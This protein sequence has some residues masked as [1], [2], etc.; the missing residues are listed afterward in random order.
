MQTLKDT[1]QVGE[2]FKNFVE[3]EENGE[4]L[5]SEAGR[6]RIYSDFIEWLMMEE[7][8]QDGDRELVNST[9]GAIRACKSHVSTLFK[10]LYEK[11]PME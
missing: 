10:L 3:K 11:S 7:I 5:N 2:S 1:Q 8:N 9:E 4:A 6:N